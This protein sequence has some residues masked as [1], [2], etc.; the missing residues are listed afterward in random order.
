MI[1][2]TDVWNKTQARQLP[3]M[4]AANVQR[5]NDG[6]AAIFLKRRPSL[7]LHRLN[8]EVVPTAHAV[9]DNY[10]KM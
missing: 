9:T 3:L 1:V 6:K 7:Q 5:R 8:E 10:Y 2:D 4:T